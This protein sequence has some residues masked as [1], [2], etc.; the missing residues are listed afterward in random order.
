MN[1]KIFFY[2]FI[3]LEF[4]F[5]SSES[6]EEISIQ[7]NKKNLTVAIKEGY[8]FNLEAPKFIICNKNQKKVFPNIINSKKIIFSLNSSCQTGELTVYF[9]DDANTFCK[10]IARKF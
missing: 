6:L 1:T 3:L 7:K 9:C 4:A 8:H 5:A 2:F 10:K